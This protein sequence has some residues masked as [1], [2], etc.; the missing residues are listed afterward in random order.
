MHSD[1]SAMI[2]LRRRFF[3]GDVGVAKFLNELNLYNP[4]YGY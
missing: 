2:R 3:T 1:K 4:R